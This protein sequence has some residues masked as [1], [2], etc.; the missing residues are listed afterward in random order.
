MYTLSEAGTDVRNRQ[1]S[2]S[3]AMGEALQEE[4]RRDARVFLR[5]EGVSQREYGPALLKEFGAQRVVNMPI[6]EAGYTGVGLGAAL[7]GLRPVVR[8]GFVD[9]MPLTM[10]QLLN[11]VGKIRYMLGGQLTVPLVISTLSIFSSL[12]F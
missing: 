5:G 2:Y 6:S 11:Q 1:L 3:E 12:S 4:M 8:I 10:D 9:L 7:T